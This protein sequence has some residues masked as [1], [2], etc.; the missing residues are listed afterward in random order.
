M[1]RCA[2]F[3]QTGVV[4]TTTKAVLSEMHRSWNRPEAPELAKLYALVAPSDAAV[5]E[6]YQRA[7]DAGVRTGK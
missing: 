3:P 1:T 2:R 6:S 5:I 7:K 4:P